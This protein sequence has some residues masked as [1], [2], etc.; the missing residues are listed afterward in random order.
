MPRKRY[1]LVKGGPKEIEISWGFAWKNFTVYQNGQVIGI[2]GAQHELKEGRQFTLT[3]GSF[4][5]VKL[6]VGF[7]KTGLEV[8][9]NL[10][11]LPGSDSD[12]VKKINTAF[13]I[14]LFVAI[15]N[16]IGGTIVAAMLK[17]YFS[18]GIVLLAY[19]LIFIGLAIGVKRRSLTALIIAIALLIIDAIAGIAFQSMSQNNMSIIWVII[20]VLFI[21]YLFQ[22]VKPLKEL[23]QGNH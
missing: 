1:S 21:I 15:I 3:D 9:H 7:G 18:I 12:P 20:R 6:N 4:L 10:Q 14:I 8:L 13:G 19:G 23:K 17:E 2:V 11:P 5:W 16:I 22:A